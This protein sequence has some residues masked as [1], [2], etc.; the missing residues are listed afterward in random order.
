MERMTDI[1]SIDLDWSGVGGVEKAIPGV[2]DVIKYVAEVVEM[3]RWTPMNY[4]PF[5]WDYSKTVWHKP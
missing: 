1:D 5:I 3:P 2:E 4:K